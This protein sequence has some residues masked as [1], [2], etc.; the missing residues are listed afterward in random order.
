MMSMRR[1]MSAR[2]AVVAALQDDAG[3]LLW[4]VREDGP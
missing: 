4:A 2:R 1:L 3:C